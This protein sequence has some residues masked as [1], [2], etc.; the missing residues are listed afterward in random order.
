MKQET[1]KFLEFIKKNNFIPSRKM[2][3]NFLINKNIKEKII[4]TI[5]IDEND[6]VI[7]I[8]PGFGA[9]TELIAQKTKKLTVIELDKRLVEFL[10]NN[11]KDVKIINDDILKFDFNSINDH[12]FKIVSNLP[13]S[14]SSKIILKILKCANFSNAL[15]MVQKE[16]ADRIVAKCGSKKYNNFT[17]LL[18]ITSNIKKEFDIPPSCFYPQPEIFSTII[19]FS[20]KSTFDF[21]NFEKLEKFLMN[22]FSQKRKTILNNLKNYYQLD[23]INKILNDFN[24]DPKTRPEQIKSEIYEK[25]YLKFYEI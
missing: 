15:L 20:K 2:G 12:E 22:C 7:E 3:Q 17:V 4:N 6:N 8:G 24:I 21:N 14:I 11:F 9:L 23:K 18:E 1:N 19:S 25:M 5:K 10:S 13:Y 16:M